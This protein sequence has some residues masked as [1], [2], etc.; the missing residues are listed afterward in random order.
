MTVTLKNDVNEKNERTRK[1]FS[2]RRLVRDEQK[3][4]KRRA[5]GFIGN[6]A[7]NLA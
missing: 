5:S 3:M 7:R 6:P 1:M 2:G 4:S